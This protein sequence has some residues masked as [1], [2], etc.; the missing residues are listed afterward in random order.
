MPRPPSTDPT[1]SETIRIR[2]TPK[3]KAK[4]QRLAKRSRMSLSA[5]LIDR[6]L[7]A[8]YMPERKT[9]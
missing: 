5:Y 7:T 8:P 4:L 9:D 3:D 2:V 6:G 1:A